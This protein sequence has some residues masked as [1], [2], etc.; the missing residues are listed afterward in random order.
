MPFPT[1]VYFNPS[2]RYRQ[3]W[4][5]VPQV[6][7]ISISNQK[8][9]SL[10]SS[11]SPAIPIFYVLMIFAIA[12]DIYLGFS[13]LAKQGV[14]IGL[15][16]GSVI[17]DIV[18]AIMPFLIESFLIKDWNHVKVEN[19]IFQKELECQC[20]KNG[21]DDEK[22]ENR[23]SRIKENQLKKYY[24][25]KSKAN[26]V[27]FILIILIFSIAFWKI[28]TFY[29]VLPPGI[30]MLSLVNGKIV[31]IFSL[32]CAVFHIIG[33]EKAFAHFMFWSIKGAE[34]HN[35]QKTDDGRKPSPT[36]IEIEYNGEFTE[37]KSGNTSIVKRDNKV[38]LE[39][40]Y[41]IKDD[42]I[43]SLINSQ[44]DMAAKMAVAIKCKENQII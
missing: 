1:N 19:Q 8:T 4:S 24:S 39:F 34:M 38:F 22:F 29:K 37:A 26:F 17:F 44:T 7:T 21:E 36:P 28:Y 30:N 25:Y 31:I 3:T 6:R 35:F 16:I 41:V 9:K 27:R 12:F 10:Y 33:S 18:L 14:S 11:L 2:D 43:D 23:K 42:E 40:I 32:L 15:I 13:I 5:L 20:K